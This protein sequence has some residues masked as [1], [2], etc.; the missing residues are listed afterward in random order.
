M[1]KV[2]DQLAAEIKTLVEKLSVG[3]PEDDADITPLI[4]TSAAD[5]VEGL[6]KD[7]TDKELLL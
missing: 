3:M 4:D 5:F 1:D 6:I 2:A 7:A